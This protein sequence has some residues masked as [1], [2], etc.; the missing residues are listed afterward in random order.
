MNRLKKHKLTKLTSFILAFIL[1]IVTVNNLF[2][3]N[4]ILKSSTNN[5]FSITH[6][7]KLYYDSV[8]SLSNSK[9]NIDTVSVRKIN[10]Q[11]KLPNKSSTTTY[12][13]LIDDLRPEENQVTNNYLGYYNFIGKHLIETIYY[14]SVDYQFIG[15]HGDKT[16]I[17]SKPKFSNDKRFFLTFKQY[18]LEGDFVGLQIWEIK[19]DSSKNE[20]ISL[21]KIFE[22]NQLLFSPVDC[23][24]DTDGTILIK[25]EAMSNHFYPNDNTDIYFWKLKYE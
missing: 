11:I 13:L 16:S 21:N 20:P 10:G 3:Q 22:L 18:G 15:Q 7:N 19:N 24:W 25:G 4:N 14:E 8:A 1:T 5:V 17:W 6:I 2:G 9:L 23:I 12:T